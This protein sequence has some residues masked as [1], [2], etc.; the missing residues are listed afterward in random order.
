MSKFKRQKNHP[1]I[2]AAT[3][4]MLK[5]IIF[6]DKKMDSGGGLVMDGIFMSCIHEKILHLK[7]LW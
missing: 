4:L 7:A 2:L 5:K 1:K 6:S 3:N